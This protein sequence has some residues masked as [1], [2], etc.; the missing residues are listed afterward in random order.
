M[1][2]FEGESDEDAQNN[3][4]MHL[5]AGDMLILCSD[6]LTDL[7]EDPE[8]LSVIKENPFDTA[9]D[10]LIQ[11][12]NARGGYDNTTVILMRIPSRGVFKKPRKRKLVLGCL[13]TLALISTIL[14]A[15][16]FGWRWWQDKLD[17][18]E[19]QSGTQ[20]IISPTGRQDL[21]NTK[22]SIP[23]ASPTFTVE[24]PTPVSTPQPSITPWPTNTP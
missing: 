19:I 24:T 18:G 6:G 15:V 11:M 20:T 8:I 9:V 14:T 4:G 21:V 16:F 17:S 22:T 1:W 2:Y 13:L 12:A 3:Q 7:V 23:E 10:R 5:I